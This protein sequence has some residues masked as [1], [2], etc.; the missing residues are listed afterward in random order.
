MSCTWVHN[1]IM[2]AKHKCANLLLMQLQYMACIPGKSCLQPH[3]VACHTSTVL[4]I[5]N[6]AF[7]QCALEWHQCNS[8]LPCL[9]EKIVLFYMNCKFT[10]WIQLGSAWWK[11][12]RSTTVWI[13]LV[14]IT[15]TLLSVYWLQ[16][17]CTCIISTYRALLYSDKPLDS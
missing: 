17:F 2:V 11:P 9:Y 1:I 15:I 3:C 12:Q 8:K 7:L 5:R 16:I 10:S 14:H 6:M 13:I 4:Q